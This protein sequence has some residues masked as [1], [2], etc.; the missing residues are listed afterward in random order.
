M[1]MRSNK[2][3]GELIRYY[4]L[5]NQYSQGDLS[6]KL[7]V[8]ESAISAWE[9]GISKPGVDIARMIA[10][11]MSITLEDFY[12]YPVKNEYTGKTYAFYETIKFDRSYLT[13]KNIDYDE[14]KSFI[15]LDFSL[16]GFTVDRSF[17]ESI[18][19][20]KL[21]FEDG[22]TV[23]P[24]E[25]LIIDTSKYRPKFSP[26]YEGLPLNVDYFIVRYTFEC[27]ELSSF[28]V[29]I[30]QNGHIAT[31]IIEREVF[32]ILNKQIGYSINLNDTEKDLEALD[33]FLNTMVFLCKNK[34]L[35]AMKNILVKKN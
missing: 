10:A 33:T 21:D 26:E 25:K 1:R 7:N 27:S 11:E 2:S 8:T 35:K 34:H 29:H 19:E 28:K 32:L 4:R 9:R 30:N 16:H 20:V 12:F 15:I 17:I 5:I 22:G 14:E 13:L 31:M 3:I 6:V 24:K 18:L 23:L